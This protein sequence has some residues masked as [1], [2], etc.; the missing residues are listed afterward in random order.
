[1]AY[2]KRYKIME[3]SP[4]GLLKEPSRY[5]TGNVFHEYYDTEQDAIDDI[6]KEGYCFD[7]VILTAMTKVWG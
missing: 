6:I 2:Q 7:L 4:D 1:M 5:Y 3:V